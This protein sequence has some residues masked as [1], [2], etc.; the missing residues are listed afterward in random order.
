LHR[1]HQRDGATM[2][3]FVRHDARP[4]ARPDQREVTHTVHH[5][6][7]NELVRRA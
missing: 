6:M 1:T 3:G 7:S 5:L 4:Q 2:T